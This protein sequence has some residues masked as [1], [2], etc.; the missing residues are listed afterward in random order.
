MKILKKEFIHGPSAGG[1]EETKKF[2]ELYIS[3][4]D[5]YKEVFMKNAPSH[6]WEDASKRFD[7]KNFSFTNVNFY[8]LAVLYSMKKVNENFLAQ[9]VPEK[10]TPPTQKIKPNKQNAKVVK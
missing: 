5:F 8:R 4:L 6:I 3:T 2:D 10:P 9:P 7:K 1:K